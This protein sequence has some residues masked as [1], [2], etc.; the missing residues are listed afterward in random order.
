[1]RASV[2]GQLRDPLMLVLLAACA[3]TVL[4]GDLTD[5]AVTAF[6]VTANT[7][8]GVVQ[9]VRADQA[10][11]ALGELITPG[12]RVRRGGSECSVPA[13][14]LVPGDV[15][16]LGEGDVVPA[17]CELLEG[18]AVLVDESTLT[19]ESVAVAKEVV[20][21]GSGDSLSSGTVVVKGRTVAL[22]VRT[23]P[24]SALGQVA[25]LMDTQPGLTPLQRRLA[26][27][28]RALALVAVL[29]SGLVLVQ[30]M[31]RGQPLELM[32]VTAIS[33][34]VAAVPE[35]LP[36][37]VTLALALGARR[38]ARRHAVVRRLPAV[39]TLGSVTVLATDKTGTL[40]QARMVVEQLWTP[41]RRV[42][43]A[44]DGYSPVGTLTSAGADLDLEDATDVI[45]Q[46]SPQV[47]RC[48]VS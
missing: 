36:A 31:L 37:V 21:D 39:E 4:T 15:V 9:E 8:I 40:T 11:T 26:G 17:D 20:G 23:G 7:A 18:T 25:I 19:G 30:G 38:M 3:L 42:S 44:G 28:G 32:V 34:T 43:V 47:Q 2:L 22:V 41:R 1:M 12:V 6:V 33:L 27:L 14:D 24:A 16:L 48:C 5:A 13:A 29:L 45:T 46:Q 10:I 35:S